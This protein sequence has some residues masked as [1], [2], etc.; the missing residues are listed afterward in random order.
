M[1]FGGF[2]IQLPAK[3]F[4]PKHHIT[5]LFIMCYNTLVSFSFCVKQLYRHGYYA[6]AY[7]EGGKGGKEQLSLCSEEGKNQH[8]STT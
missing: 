4:V 6:M 3:S 2:L 7:A 8:Q 1:I 5:L